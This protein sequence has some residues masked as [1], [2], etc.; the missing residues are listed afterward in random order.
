[1]IEDTILIVDDEENVISALKRIFMDDA[2]NVLSAAS[3]LEGIELLK[4]NA[5]K[6]VIS[7]EQMPGMSGSEFLS[8]IRQEYPHVVRI[9]LTGH[10]SIEAAMKAINDGEIYRFFIKPW[11][12]YEI[13][14]TVKAA[15]EKFNLE[16]ELRQK[17]ELI[18]HMA[19]HDTLTGLPN[20]LLLYDRLTKALEYSQRYSKMLSI[21]FLDLDGFKT[22]NDIFG[23]D[24]GDLLLKQVSERLKMSVRKS[25]TIA[26][27]GG[28][29]FIIMLQDISDPEDA[30]ITAGKIVNELA[31]SFVTGGQ[32]LSIT[33]SVGVSLY[34][35]DGTDIETLMKKADTAMYNAKKAGKNNFRLYCSDK[36]GQDV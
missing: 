36:E 28:D 22:I 27:L 2:I 14:T 34:P 15:I 35:S 31:K 9:I 8:M 23:H 30:E 18:K 4:Q 16:E 11:N 7:D 12:N 25:D 5:V 19:Y 24:T 20:R 3:A 26:R 6:L 13:R 17:E 21:C 32:E 33:V 29:E 10:A 1:M